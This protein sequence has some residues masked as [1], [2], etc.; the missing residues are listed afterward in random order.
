MSAEPLVCTCDTADDEAR[1]KRIRCFQDLVHDLFLPVGCC[2][3]CRTV[4]TLHKETFARK[5]N[6][7]TGFL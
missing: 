5:I 7:A 6:F 4:E 2:Y 1:A 3:G